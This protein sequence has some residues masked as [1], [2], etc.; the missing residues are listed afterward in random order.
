MKRL[1]KE[2]FK[3]ER[4]STAD[5]E[6]QG[7]NAQQTDYRFAMKRFVLDTANMSYGPPLSMRLPEDDMSSRGSYD[8]GVQVS[9][10]SEVDSIDELFQAVLHELEVK[11]RE[12]H[13]PQKE[14]PDQA[15]VARTGEKWRTIFRKTI[16]SPALSFMGYR[17]RR[18]PKRQQ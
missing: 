8:T 7:S 18:R 13:H 6:F 4:M 11:Y 2:G 12:G 1:L 14:S 17:I 3:L 15:T 9:E 10:A 16:V 5:S